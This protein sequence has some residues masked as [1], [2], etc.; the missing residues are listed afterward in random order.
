MFQKYLFIS[1]QFIC[2]TQQALLLLYFKEL[3]LREEIHHTLADLFI[4][5]T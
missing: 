5:V 2:L 1:M 4:H 3:V